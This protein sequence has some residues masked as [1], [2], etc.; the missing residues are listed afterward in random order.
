MAVSVEE[1]VRKNV[2]LP[3]E[4]LTRIVWYFLVAYDSTKVTIHRIYNRC[5]AI[6]YN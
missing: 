6:R 5:Y 4:S 3:V 2:P 1:F